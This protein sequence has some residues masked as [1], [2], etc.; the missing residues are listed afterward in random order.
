M[1]FP[2]ILGVHQG[3]GGGSQESVLGWCVS[4]HLHH[5]KVRLTHLRLTQP[6]A[7][8]LKS[9]SGSRDRCRRVTGLFACLAG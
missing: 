7:P 2:L 4:V 1:R 5:L 6:E 9:Q 3:G 8:T